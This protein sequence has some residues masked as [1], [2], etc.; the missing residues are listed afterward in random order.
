LRRLHVLTVKELKQCVRDLVLVAFMAYSFIGAVYISGTG[1]TQDLRNASMLIHDGS[2]TP[3]SRDLLYLFR[4][5]YF[6]RIGAF[7][8]QREGLAR[9]DDGTAM[10]LVDIPTDFAR[11]M[12]R[13]S[14]SAS[15]QMLV[16]T[17]NVTL[18]YLAAAY[19]QRIAATYAQEQS[20]HAAAR[21]GLDLR[22]L[23]SVENVSRV[24][25]NPNL[26][27]HWFNAIGQWLTMMTVVAV[28]LPAT[29]LVR[30]RER[31]TV[32]QLLVAPLTPMQIMVSKAFAM[33]L[34]N[35]VGTALSVYAVMLP[36]IGVPFAGSAWLFFGTTALYVFSIA[37]LG[38]AIGAFARSSAEV[39]ML[40]ILIAVPMTA[41]SGTWT[42][43]EAMPQWSRYALQISPLYHFISCAYGILLRGADLKVLW[44]SIL[45]LAMLGAAAF[46]L[47]WLRLQQKLG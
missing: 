33:T 15:V 16:D 47:A 19:G 23:P 38:L 42:A 6:T 45:M 40:V 18:G 36:L 3:Q 21:S 2:N 41:L 29:A 7:V 31:G 28:L 9:L 39:G 24:W 17:S 43:P 10:L 13:T 26:N 12:S 46:G 1:V 25:Y 44:Q 5:P 32:E 27:G 11:D 14:R 20:R 22:T 34:V 37:G 8:G 30:E 4:Q 35:L